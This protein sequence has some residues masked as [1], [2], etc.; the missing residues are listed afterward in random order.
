IRQ[1]ITLYLI[2]FQQFIRTINF[3]RKVKNTHL[4]E[5]LQTTDEISIIQRQ[6]IATRLYIILFIVAIVIIVT[7]TG[8]NSQIQSIK[9]SSPTELIFEQL[10][11]QYSSSS[12]S[13]PCSQISVQYSKFIS[14]KPI[15]YHQVC[16]SYFISS[17]FIQL[18]WGN[19]SL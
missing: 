19:E 2:Q 9:V 17:N 11:L 12:L 10:Q 6:Q 8:L 7:F 15:A 4:Q 3:Y 16:S 5:I 1:R 13:C 18:L 14:I